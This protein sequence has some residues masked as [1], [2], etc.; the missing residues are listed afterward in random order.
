MHA[1]IRT[2]SGKGAKELF[3]LLEQ[4]KT[5]IETV[6]RPIKGF[7][8]YTAIRSGDGGLELLFSHGVGLPCRV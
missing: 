8:S 3:D 5:D 2:Y 6:M 4:R 1:V 7:V